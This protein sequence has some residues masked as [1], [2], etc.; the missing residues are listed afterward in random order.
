MTDINSAILKGIDV[1]NLTKQEGERSPII[2]FLTDGHASYGVE[3]D[4]EILKNIEKANEG[5][6]S[7]I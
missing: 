6:I 3:N 7:I 5:N 2:L 1:F 4:H